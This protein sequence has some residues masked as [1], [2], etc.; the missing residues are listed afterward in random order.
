LLIGNTKFTVRSTATSGVGL[1]LSAGAALF[2]VLWWA[3]HI[4]RGRR[5]A[6]LLSM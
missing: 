6:R 2:L 1:L 5:T 3:R 4:L